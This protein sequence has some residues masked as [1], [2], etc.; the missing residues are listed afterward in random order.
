MEKKSDSSHQGKQSLDTLSEVILAHYL[1]Y[2]CDYREGLTC[3]PVLFTTG[4]R[5]FYWAI[6]NNK[7]CAAGLTL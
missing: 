6:N 4:S 3:Q 1:R 5:G 7:T 2:V